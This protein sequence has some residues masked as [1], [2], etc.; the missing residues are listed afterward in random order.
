M[1]QWLTNLTR[2]HEDVGSIPGLAHWGSG[3]AVG[4]SVGCRCGSDPLL[5]WLW[6]RLVVTVAPIWPLARE[7]SCAKS[8]ALK[9][10]K[11]KKKGR[12]GTYT[13]WN[14][15]LSH[16]K[17]QINTICSNIDGTR[18][19]HTKWNQSERERYNMIPLT[20]GNLKYGTGK[21]IHWIEIDLQAWTA[22]LWL[23]GWGAGGRSGIDWKF[24]VNRCKP[25]HLEWIDNEVLLYNTGNSV[26]F[27]VM[28]YDER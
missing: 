2:A 9:G 3:L 23:S 7:L 18:D 28:K 14:I 19:F 15:L 12:C 5:L 10:K 11:K 21:P 4:C 17:E 8:K 22:E 27:L 25:L 13:Q 20:Y 1:A 16:K 6:L 26:Q 24:G